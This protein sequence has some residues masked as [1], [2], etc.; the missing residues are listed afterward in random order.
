[1]S[2]DQRRINKLRKN[3]VKPSGINTTSEKKEDKKA[4]DTKGEEGKINP[5][6]AQIKAIEKIGRKQ[7]HKWRT[8]RED[9]HGQVQETL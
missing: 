3:H 5:S 6:E 9:I 2:R 7:R 1:M 4:P 8:D